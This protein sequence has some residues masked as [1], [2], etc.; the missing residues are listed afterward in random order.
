MVGDQV[1]LDNRPTLD[2]A[3][4]YGVQ[5]EYQAVVVPA[6]VLV[7]VAATLPRPVHTEASLEFLQEARARWY[8]S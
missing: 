8:S 3:D 4:R 5:P 1:A 7:A 6:C 2:E